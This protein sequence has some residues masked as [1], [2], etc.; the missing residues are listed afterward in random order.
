MFKRAIVSELEK[1]AKKTNRKPLVIRGARQVGKTTVV[2][3]IAKRFDQY[4]YL[5]LELSADGQLF[6]DFENIDSLVE[7]IF[8]L[9]KQQLSKKKKTL[10]FIDEIQEVPDA[11]NT[12]R[13][14]HEQIPELAV[15][16]AGSLLETLFDHETNFPVGRVSYLVLRPV[17]FIEYL[18]AIGE[19]SALEQL[20][21]IPLKTFAHEKLLQLFHTYALI[22]GM[23]EI[24]KTYAET[25]DLTQL[26]PLYDA[27]I[28]GYIDDIEKYASSNTQVNV[29]RHVIKSS[30]YEVNK[31]IKFQGF[32]KS[33]YGSKEIG[34][35]LR[36]LEK[37]FLL[38]LVYPSTTAQL[39]MLPEVQKSPRLQLLDTGLMNF[40]AGIQK[41]IIGTKDLNGVYNGAVIEHLVG[42]ELLAMHYSTLHTLHFWVREKN[43]S[44]AEVDYII[45]YNSKVIPIEVKSGKEGKLKS[46]HL[47][48]EAA[49]HQMA[50]RFYAGELTITEV[51][52]L[53]NKHYYLLNLPY[54]LVSQLEKYLEWME[55]QLKSKAKGK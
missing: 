6:K 17:S 15:I 28:T 25:K 48:M 32:G 13:Y 26:A 9:K 54:Y 50:V 4:I 21:H 35:A 43:T 41:D 42:Q 34:D 14:F 20:Q 16:A 30:Y 47:F 39:P 40:S 12:L 38:H 52:T 36:T 18:A 1:W 37:A 22:G 29:I 31:R 5:N 7:S 55:E 53:N 8:F 44:T 11:F 19:Y 24:V 27:L 45:N 2:E 46:L 49:N 23:P 33:S 3:Q 10:L 51:N